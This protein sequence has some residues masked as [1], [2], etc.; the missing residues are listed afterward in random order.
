MILALNLNCSLDKIYTVAALPHGGVARALSTENTA[1][2]KGLHVANVCSRLGEEYL[3]TGFLGGHIG[4]MIMEILS[5]K[6]IHQDFVTIQGE[7]RSCINI[8]T[9]DGRQ[10][11]VLEAGPVVSPVEMEAFRTKYRMLLSSVNVVVGSGSLPQGVPHTFYA[12]LISLARKAGKHFLLD[13][14]GTTL[15]DSLPAQPF[16]I[17]PNRDEI[18]MLT[19][20]KISTPEDA[21]RELRSFM[22][23][24]VAFPVI[25]L[26]ADGSV[27]GWKGRVYRIRLPRLNVI[28]AVGS[29][30][31]FVAGIAIGLCRGYDVEEMLRFASACGAANVL[32]KESGMVSPQNGERIFAQ[33]CVEVLESIA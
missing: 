1:G 12:E 15:M 24:G 26:G 7:T 29:G 23:N 8:G 32:E 10:T 28:N 27:A 4:A 9:P 16:F 13:T 3:V 22:E 31:S 17:K 25:S 20:H 19:G 30:D 5:K 6:G 14:S 11:E 21:V 18:E 2:G 33:T